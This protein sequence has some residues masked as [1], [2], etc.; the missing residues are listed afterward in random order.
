MKRAIFFILAFF[1]IFV[2]LFALRA[3]V[4]KPTYVASLL[5]IEAPRAL[6]P[7][8]S[9]IVR[10]TVKNIGTATWVN[11]G[12]NYTSLYRYDRIKHVEVAS[13]FATPAWKNAKQPVLL[14]VSSVSP[15][16]SVIFSFPIT[17]PLTPGHYQEDFEFA[18]ENIA[19]MKY[20]IFSLDITVGAPTIAAAVSSAPSAFSSTISSPVGFAISTPPVSVG[21]VALLPW[22]SEIADRGGISWQVDSEQRFTIDLAFKNM[23]KNTWHRDGM[24]YVSLYATEGTKE[25]ASGFHDSK[26][27]SASHAG[28]LTETQVLPGDIGHFHFFVSAP[29]TAGVF[30]ETFTLAAEDAAWIPGSSITLP[31]RVMPP[32]KNGFIAT[33]YPGSPDIVPIT[34]SGYK[35]ALTTRS[36]GSLSGIGDARET[37]S[38]TFKNVGTLTWSNRSI[39]LKEILPAN[40]LAASPRDT[41]WMNAVEA[42]QLS[43]ETRPGDVGTSNFLFKMP[44][45]KGEY[46]VKFQL[47][48][49]GMPVNGGEIE[50]PLSVTRDGSLP[51]PPRV[52]IP[53]LPSL[54]PLP[55]QTASSVPALN[56]IPLSGDISTLPNEPIIRVGL[57]KTTD[58]Q[59]VV[60][61]MTVPV[62]VS[63][64]GTTICRLNSGESTTVHYDR[65][66]RVYKLFGG[67]CVG[68]SSTWY[69]L[70]TE[71][72]L[73]P[74][75]M[76][77]YSRPVSW[78]PGANDNKFRAELELR[79]T[80][81]TDSVWVMNELPV[82]WYLK[83]IGE[84]SNSS[85]QEFQRTLLTTARTYAM[86][87]VSRGTKHANESF[88]IDATYDQ[89]YRGYGAEI[90]NPNVAAA[91]DATRGQIVTYNGQLA[92]TPYFSR[93]DGRTRSWTEVWGGGPYPWMV[94][95]PVP[96]DAGKT[97]WGHGVGMSATGALGM[98]NDGRKYDEILKYFYQGIELRRAYK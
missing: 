95:V 98:A 3:A 83:G 90:R 71:D 91:V 19:W 55:S 79:Y 89:V 48:V 7:G 12:A 43:S 96:W 35:A 69:V 8:A 40:G 25:R 31:I 2:P 49:S 65:T 16:N 78:S 39:R 57:F 97:L 23:G 76:T 44:A 88:I 37:F 93:S 13:V 52:S 9:G 53:S 42:V 92:I 17:A 74:M 59:M 28:L 29:K 73:S 47:Y 80:P 94:S 38:V 1:G 18:A 5:N 27:L 45:Q 72:N 77:D 87:H 58:D 50:I 81:L 4:A 34:N 63:Q 54:T 67:P 56:P 41:S 11:R 61:A 75:E 86:Y 21:S 51:S 46:H 60:R 22:N 14:P 15:R 64:N 84:T 24:A 68:Q 30:Q 82:E 26:W 6:A 66:N 32:A 33:A 70:R 36:A 10:V 85:P 20:G 62:I